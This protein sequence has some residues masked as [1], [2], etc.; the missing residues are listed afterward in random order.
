MNT[1]ETDARKSAAERHCDLMRQGFTQMVPVERPT[2]HQ[3]RSAKERAAVIIA[4][5]DRY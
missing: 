2:E 5:L 4:I 3:I 1:N